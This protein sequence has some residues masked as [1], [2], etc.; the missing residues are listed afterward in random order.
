MAWVPHSA[1]D[2]DVFGGIGEVFDGAI[3]G[4]QTPAK[5]KG[6]WGLRRGEGTTQAMEQRRQGPSS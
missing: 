5:A 4:H 2:G 6:T 1:K 3:N